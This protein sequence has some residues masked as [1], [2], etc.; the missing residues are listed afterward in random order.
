ME[1][2]WR[3]LK[4]LRKKCVYNFCYIFFCFLPI[5]YYWLVF[6]K[7]RHYSFFIF[8]K[9]LFWIFSQ[10]L[11]IEEFCLKIIAISLESCLCNIDR[12]YDLLAISTNFS[13]ILEKFRTVTESSEIWRKYPKTK[14]TEK[15]REFLKKSVKRWKNTKMPVTFWKYSENDGNIKILEKLQIFRKYLKRPEY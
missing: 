10:F 8:F 14:G 13:E 5:D 15:L 12:S 6:A 7:N 2:F 9:L 4:I 1:C 11:F 3:F